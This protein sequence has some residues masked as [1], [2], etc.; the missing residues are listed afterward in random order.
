MDNDAPMTYGMYLLRTKNDANM[1]L[2]N[3][4]GKIKPDM[5]KIAMLKR[6]VVQLELAYA[7][8]LIEISGEPTAALVNI[9]AVLSII[10]SSMLAD[11]VLKGRK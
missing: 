9:I 8:H 6:S 10:D 1:D 7:Q 4:K 3:E 2:Y 5:A 11:K